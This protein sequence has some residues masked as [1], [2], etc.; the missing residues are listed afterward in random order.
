MTPEEAA[1]KA[2]SLFDKGLHCSQAVFQAGSESHGVQALQVIKALAPFGGGMGGS[3]GICGALPG[4]LA[5]MGLI[6]GKETP[7]Q[8]D[9]RSLWRSSSSMIKAFSDIT[10]VYGGTNCSDIARVDWTDIEQIK[11]FRKSPDSRRKE[12][13]K[14]IGET[15]RRLIELLDQVGRPG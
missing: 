10:A 15:T 2:I 3:G 8:R 1:G 7:S 5:V 6:M 9:H 14:V 12:C 11:R 13:K 4:A